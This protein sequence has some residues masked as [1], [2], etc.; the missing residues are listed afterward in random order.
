METIKL[1]DL[2]REYK[3]LKKEIDPVIFDVIKSG[4]FVL[5]KDID[6]FEK[7]FAKYCGCKRAVGVASGTAA[8]H[9]ALLAIGIKQGDEI[10]TTPV[11]FNATP[12]A[13]VI[14]GATPVFV[15]VLPENLSIN[16]LKIEKAITQKTKA[17]LPVHLYGVP[18]DIDKIMSICKKYKLKLVEDC[19]QAHGATY[20]NK[21]LGTFGD[22][23]CFSFMPKKN[24]GCYGDG[25][26]IITNNDEYADKI[27]KLRDHGRTT[28]YL[29]DEMGYAER[30][31]N[32]HAAILSVKLRHLDIW[33]AKRNNLAEIYKNGL[34]ATKVGFLEIPSFCYPSY[35]VFPILVKNRE[36][37]IEGLKKK[38]VSTGIHYPIALHLQPVFKKFGYK[39]GD[40]PIAEKLVDQILSL[41]MN[42]FITKKE[43]NYI[44]KEFNKI[45]K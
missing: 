15:D 36:N 33:N 23:G 3:F 39:K 29:H 28:K 19:A 18:A 30:M 32:L 42:P 21:K 44:I 27:K 9:L 14:A 38:G 24:I 10:I 8:L 20:K 22:I 16:P 31:D 37:I 41:P 1:V 5:E 26:S 25:G 11:S 40:L 7:K 45:V 43:A 17:I 2:I 35:Y 34:D 13:I 4:R 12:E 6:E